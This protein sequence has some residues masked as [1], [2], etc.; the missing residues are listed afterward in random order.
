M[1]LATETTGTETTGT[2]EAYWMPGCSSCL[3]MKEFIQKSGKD[4]VAINIDESVEVQAEL[5]KRNMVPPVAHFGD[6][7]VNGVDLAAVAELI[8]VEYNPP[9]IMPAQDLV[10]RYNANLDVAR[11]IISVMTDEMFAFSLPNRERKMFD[12]ANQVASVMRAF[13]EA[14]Y[15]DNHTTKSYG[16]PAEVQTKQDILDRLDETRRLFTL[17]WTE[18]GFDDPLDRVTQTYWGFPTLLEV[19][20]RE[21]WHTTQHIRQLD[22]VLKEFDV[23]P[24]LPLTKANLDGLPLP[25]GIHD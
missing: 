17:W 25:E 21:I 12:V 23:T 22:Y 4:W 2:V 7:W 8:G 24:P 13:L 3:R 11:G 5:A 16:K 1:A 9:V 20:E 6:R 14:Y 15:D 19:L 10:D 18:D